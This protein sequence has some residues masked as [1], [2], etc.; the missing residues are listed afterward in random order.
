MY[1]IWFYDRDSHSTGKTVIG[2]IDEL[3]DWFRRNRG[4]NCAVIITN[5]CEHREHEEEEE[6]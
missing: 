2:S 1:D 6:D 5:I 3:Y 4:Y